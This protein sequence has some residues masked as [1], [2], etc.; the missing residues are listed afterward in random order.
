MI[1]VTVANQKG[2]VGKT[3]TAATVAHGLALK[4]YNVLCVDL[5]PQGQIASHL[6]LDQADGVFNLLVSRMPL[7]DV[8]QSTER[9]RL[10]LVPGSKRTKTAETI[11]VVEQHPISTLR[12]LLDRQAGGSKLHYIVLDTAPSAGGL[13]EHALYAADVLLIPAAV[14]YLSLEGVAQVL[15]TL[16]A[17]HRPQPPVVRILPTFFDEVTRESRENLQRL[18]DKFGGTLLDPV[19]R[20]A[21]LRECPALGQTIFEHDPKSRAAEEYAAVTWGVINAT[22]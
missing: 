22:R 5:D 3:T 15:R 19:H 4:G 12:Q 21:V 9:S 6:G 14:D 10:W 11:F 16:K 18:R 13:Q 2:G 8:A 17:I 20:A 7:R 1:I